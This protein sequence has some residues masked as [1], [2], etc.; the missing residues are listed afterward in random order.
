MV[1]GLIIY[2]DHKK[3][4]STPSAK[5]A[6]LCVSIVDIFSVLICTH[7]SGKTDCALS[8]FMHIRSGSQIS[9]TLSLVNLVSRSDRIRSLS[10]EVLALNL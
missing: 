8:G 4:L 1:E 9:D 7:L 5:N 3:Y 6:D 2:F 10:I